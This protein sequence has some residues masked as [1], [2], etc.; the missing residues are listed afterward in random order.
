MPDLARSLRSSRSSHPRRPLPLRALLAVAAL[1][2]LAASSLPA[3]AAEDVAGGV[4]PQAHSATAHHG[5]EA[6]LV[7]PN[8]GQASPFLMIGNDEKPAATKASP[9]T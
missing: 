9:M 7:L 6:N 5:G 4:A 1:V 3:F 8:L 2:L